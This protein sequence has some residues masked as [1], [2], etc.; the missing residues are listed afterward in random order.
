MTLPM[1]LALPRTSISFGTG[2][3]CF[4]A[5]A[6]SASMASGLRVG[7][8]PVKV[9]VPVM[10]EAAKATPG[11]TD[12]ATIT[13]ASHKLF[14]VLRMLGSLITR[15]ASP[16]RTPLTLA[17]GGPNAPLRSRGSLVVLV[18]L[19]DYAGG[20]APPHPPHARSRGPQRPAPLAWLTRRTRSLI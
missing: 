20:F 12:T 14:P 16:R 2:A 13:P 1:L 18:R 19:F 17:R 5:H 3:V 6:G 10:D 11:Q 7:A 15:G 8:F 4:L 9:T